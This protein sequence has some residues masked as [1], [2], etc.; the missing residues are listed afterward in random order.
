MTALLATLAWAAPPFVVATEGPDFGDAAR[1]AGLELVAT[2]PPEQACAVLEPGVLVV[3]HGTDELRRTPVEPPS[4]LDEA[5]A[6][7]L[8]AMSL[9]RDVELVL[10]ELPPVELPAPV[11]RPPAPVLQAVLPGALASE[12][13]PGFPASVSMGVPVAS[14]VLVPGEPGIVTSPPPTWGLAAGA[15]VTLLGEAL[16]GGAQVGVG[17]RLGGLVYQELRLG[18]TGGATLERGGRSLDLD[19]AELALPVAWHGVRGL[20]AGIGPG[21]SVWTV[22]SQDQVVA[23]STTPGVTLRTGWTWRTVG[24]D[25]ELRQDVVAVPVFLND[26]LVGTLPAR[27]AALEVA[28]WRPVDPLRRSGAW[29]G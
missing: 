16:G 10:P 15:G 22:A 23:R 4:S 5:D 28:W 26:E 29:R 11:P 9:L 21:V 17:R 27:T 2:C 13:I 1:Y 19:R 6:I 8:L 12:A 14:Q 25:L 7:A 3:R 20:H 24:I 18:W